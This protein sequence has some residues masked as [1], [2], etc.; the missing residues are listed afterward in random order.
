MG[1][2]DDEPYYEP[3]LV[4]DIL[5]EYQQKMKDALLESVK[6][7]IEKTKT[8]NEN[9]KAENKKLQKQ[10]SEINQ[11]EREL[12][13]QKKNLIWEVRRERLSKLMED[14]KIIMYQASATYVKQPKCDKCNKDRQIAF[15]SPSGKTVHEDCEC[16]KSNTIYAPKANIVYEFKVDRH[17]SEKMS[18]WYTVEESS[19]DKEEYYSHNTTFA[20]TIYNTEMSF[21]NLNTYKTFFKTI[22]ECQTYCDW[23]NKKNNVRCDYAVEPK[24]ST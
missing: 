21:E 20:E 24:K 18:A 15:K 23:L 17:N 5:N 6:H 7:Q 2:Y 13:T 14:F 3:S 1:Y 9:L 10:V 11:K 16:N 19:Y 12:E 22:E 8:D 4:D